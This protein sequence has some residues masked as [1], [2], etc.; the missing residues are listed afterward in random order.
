MGSLCCIPAAL[1]MNCDTSCHRFIFTSPLAAVHRNWHAFEI[2]CYLLE[3]SHEGKRGR[4]RTI[5]G[6]T[7]SSGIWKESQHWRLAPFFPPKRDG[8]LRENAKQTRREREAQVGVCG[9]WRVPAAIPL[10]PRDPCKVVGCIKELGLSPLSPCLSQLLWN[11]APGSQARGR[12]CTC[13]GVSGELWFGLRRTG[14][15]VGKLGTQ[16]VGWGEKPQRKAIW[17]PWGLGFT[18]FCIQMVSSGT[19]VASLSLGFPT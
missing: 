9:G 14:F 10:D 16:D 13:F 2:I 6:D 4:R 15:V 3:N 5:P 1:S 12:N 18:P 17:S 19:P 8:G 7:A 11:S